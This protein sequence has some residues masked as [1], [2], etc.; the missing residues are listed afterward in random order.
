MTSQ[1]PW[2]AERLV[3]VDHARLLIL[4][5]F[6]ELSLVSVTL[7]GEGWDNIAYLVND[8]WIFRFPRREVAVP[9]MRMENLILHAIAPG[10]PAAVPVPFFYAEGGEGYD[11]PFG[12]YRLIEGVTACGANLRHQDRLVI[13]AD[14]GRFLRALHDFPVSEAE[15][16]GA[17]PDPL[18]RM[19]VSGRM[20]KL[21]QWFVNL[22]NHQLIDA[23]TRRKLMIIV[24]E[25]QDIIP[26]DRKSLVHGDLYA[27]HIVVGRQPCPSFRLSG[28]I[29]WGDI[30]IGHRAIDLGVMYTILPAPARRLFL[31]GYNSNLD[32]ETR[33]LARFRAVNHNAAVLNYAAEIGDEALIGECT[34]SF[35]HILQD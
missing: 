23:R 32:E 21:N 4:E 2:L 7:M 13:A 24:N 28:I 10:L 8:E 17:K 19:D 27:R 18:G 6:P 22:E 5:N 9:L 15:A 14:L 20:E 33:I 25:A 34:Q 31:D 16:L 3:S 29:D 11:W 35:V 30:N 26:G 1:Q 12:G